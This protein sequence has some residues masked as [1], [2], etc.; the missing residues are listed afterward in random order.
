[1]HARVEQVAVGRLAREIDDVNDAVRIDHGLR[2][3]AA[4]RKAEDDEFRVLSCE[5]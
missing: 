5:R 2:L 1:L 3:D 4:R